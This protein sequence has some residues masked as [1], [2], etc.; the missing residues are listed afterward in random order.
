MLNNGLIKQL[1]EEGKI[2]QI[3]EMIERGGDEGMI[4]FDQSL[5]ELYRKGV[6]S[7]E[8]AIAEADN[9]ANLRL[10]ITQAEVK[11]GSKETISMRSIQR[12]DK[13]Q[14]KPSVTLSVPKEKS[15]F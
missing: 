4:T 14:I 15:E 5:F 7:D 8:V 2:R 6:I 9:P 12:A 13:P 3:R 10:A 1:I 11:T